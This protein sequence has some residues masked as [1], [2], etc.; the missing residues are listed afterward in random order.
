MLQQYYTFIKD[1]IIF[2]VK[3]NDMIHE[4]VEEISCTRNLVIGLKFENFNN[5]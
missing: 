1:L 3:K 2:N 4:T 5:L